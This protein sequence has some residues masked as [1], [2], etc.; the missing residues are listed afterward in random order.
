MNESFDMSIT[1]AFWSQNMDYS[2]YLHC[3]AC[4]E[5]GLYCAKHRIEVETNLRKREIRKILQIRD[6][7]SIQ[8][9]YAIK[10]LL[11]SYNAWKIPK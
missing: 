4:Q 3:H 1:D 2:K 5:S 7:N 9:N 11:K 10:G 8:F 6:C